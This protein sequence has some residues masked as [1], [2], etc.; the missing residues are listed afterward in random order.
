MSQPVYFVNNNLADSFIQ[1]LFVGCNLN[2]QFEE[3][4]LKFARYDN[5]NNYWHHNLGGYG[6]GVKV[7]YSYRYL[8]Y[9]ASLGIGNREKYY[10]ID[11]ETTELEKNWVFFMTGYYLEK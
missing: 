2:P 6:H 1:E 4:F 9:M 11:E 3:M 5:F 7:P 10:Y 8:T